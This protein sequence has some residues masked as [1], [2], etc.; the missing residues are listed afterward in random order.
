MPPSHAAPDD[1]VTVEVHLDAGEL[2]RSLREDARRGLLSRPKALPPKWFY[3]EHGSRLFERIT[4]LPEYYPT[5]RE[6][7]ILE[8]RAPE[9]ARLTT[10]DT[11]I[12]LGSGFSSKTRLLLDALAG[13]LRL[14][15]PFD[16][17]EPTL[18]QAS[19]AIAREHAGLRVHAVVGDFQRHVGLLPRRGRRLIAFLGSTIGNLTPDERAKLL[20][21]LAGGMGP[22]DA[23]LLGT[24]LVK[25]VGRVE[26]AY[27]DGA[28]VTA[29]FNLN[30]LR[31]L[32][33]EL[34]AD[35]D[36]DR[37]THR[38]LWVPGPEWIEMR[39]R[40]EVAHE[41]RLPA[42][43][44]DVAFAQGEELRTEISAKFRR[45]GVEAELAAAG[46]EPRRWWTDPASDFALSLAAPG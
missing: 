33:R 22:G 34:G 27:N 2:T 39:L 15:V 16:V 9:L 6:R 31:V 8:A 40:A 1:R 4:Q 46:L 38:A 32:N 13:S 28:G 18:R 35:F 12:E 36:L 42:I 17:S 23:L 30:V 5:R 24:D 37:F 25:D 43:G 14:F 20:A 3:D 7:E 11:L 41:V 19:G 45:A 44:L 10:P 29:E 26:A 21:D